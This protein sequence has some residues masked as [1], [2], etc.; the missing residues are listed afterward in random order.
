MV[1]ARQAPQT[2]PPMIP[3]CSRFDSV[4]FTPKMP[5]ISG[6]FNF[7][8]SPKIVLPLSSMCTLRVYLNPSGASPRLTVVR[9]GAPGPMRIGPSR[10]AIKVTWLTITARA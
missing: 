4:L 7:S 1:I 9:K 5:A 6:S 10:R 2:C 8:R 3:F